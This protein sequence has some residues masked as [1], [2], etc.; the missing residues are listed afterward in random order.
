MHRNSLILL[1]V[2]AMAACNKKTEP[3]K[4]VS[5]AT[6]SQ[7]NKVQ[8]MGA[9]MGGM[10]QGGAQAPA[11]SGETIVGKVLEKVDAAGY[12]YLKLSANGGDQWAAVPQT[13]T[14]IGAEVTVLVSM[15]MDGFESQTLKRK[16]D[17]L[18]FATLGGAAAPAAAANAGGQMPPGHP[19]TGGMPAM[20]GEQ[21]AAGAH[22]PPAAIEDAGPIKVA[23]AEGATGRTVAEVWAQKA[24][25][26]G[27]EVAVRGKVVKYTPGVMGH[28]W[29]HV[30]DGSGAEGKD[31]DLVVVTDDVTEKGAV[32]VVKG[33]VDTDRNLGMGY[34][35]DVLVDNAKLTK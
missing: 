30:R 18:V 19:A 16:F 7:A 22:P 34:E 1:A 27:K 20:G 12:S 32:V 28:N 35:F 21:A 4:P 8:R 29:V 31:N 10:Q 26:K 17:K 33:K 15:H 24:E 5:E 23:K 14:A 13:D 9:G 3:V 6:A 2:L 11:E 25:L